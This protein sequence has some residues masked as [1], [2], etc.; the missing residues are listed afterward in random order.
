M[1]SGQ[2][3]AGGRCSVCLHCSL[4]HR[5]VYTVPGFVP[6]QSLLSSPLGGDRKVFGTTD[7]EP[8]ASLDSRKVGAEGSF[9]GL[10]ARQGKEAVSPLPSRGGHWLLPREELY[11]STRCAKY[12]AGSPPPPQVQER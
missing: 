2:R 3:E 7:Q 6:T 9:P 11:P 10:S 8:R 4:A 12:T 1:S 5:S